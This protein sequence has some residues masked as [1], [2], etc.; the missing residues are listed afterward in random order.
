[1]RRVKIL[2]GICAVALLPLT[3]A[4]Q[5]SSSQE[6]PDWVEGIRLDLDNSYIDIATATGYSEDEARNKA[7]NSIAVKRDWGTGKR[8]NVKIQN[9]NVVAEGQGELTIKA[10]PVDEYRE[11]CAN[12]QYR[13]SL[14]VQ[15]AKNPGP[16]FPPERINITH[17]YASS[18]RAF[19]PGMAQLHK[20]SKVKGV[21]FIAG[22]VALIGGLVLAENLRASYT[23]KINTTHSASDKKT[24]LNNADN[25]QNIRNGFIAGAAAL[26][27]WNVIDG[28]VAK[29]KKHIVV[30][31][32]N[33][34]RIAPYA[35]PEAGGI[36]LTLN[37]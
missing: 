16:D 6:R 14:L 21:F 10:L 4:G 25:W 28:L 5:C 35:T 1:M 27:A 36:A 19:V 7:L 3:A 18:A 24:Y 12:G 23:A 32:D 26:Y 11:Y 20:G 29:G 9:G 30:L 31:G 17:D 8:L 22:E 37:F 34:L 15:T 13:V 2:T 33:T